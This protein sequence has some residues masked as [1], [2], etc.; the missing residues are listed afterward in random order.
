[1]AEAPLSLI[2]LSISDEFVGKICLNRRN[3]RRKS[4]IE[5]REK[6]RNDEEEK[7]INFRVAKDFLEKNLTFQRVQNGVKNPL[8]K[9][10]FVTGEKISKDLVSLLRWCLPQK[11]LRYN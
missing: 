9:L 6:C 5:K 7:K 2:S 11:N 8:Q 4:R 3:M 10:P 1:M